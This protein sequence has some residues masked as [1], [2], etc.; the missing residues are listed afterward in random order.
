MLGTSLTALRV[1][2]T[3]RAFE[4]IKDIN[5]DVH[6]AIGGKGI[7]AIYALF[8][9][10]INR[11]IEEVYLEDLLYSYEDIISSKYYR[12]DPRLEV[13][14]IAR[15]FDISDLVASLSD[16]KV[17]IVNP[18]DARGEIARIETLGGMKVYRY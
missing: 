11:D 4:Y 2:D 6:L 18:R 14:G 8:A 7:S 16:R 15:Y 9:S 1:F 3:L 12:Y 10:V 5:P 17:M 13:Y